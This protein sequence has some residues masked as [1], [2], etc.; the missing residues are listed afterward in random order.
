MFPRSPLVI[1]GVPGRPDEHGFHLG[2][3][4]SRGKTRK[5]LGVH[6]QTRFEE[7]QQQKHR[8]LVT[9][10]L[11]V[12]QRLYRPSLKRDLPWSRGYGGVR[13]DTNS[14][15]LVYGVHAAPQ[16]LWLLC[17]TKSMRI[18]AQQILRS[19]IYNLS[20]RTP[21]AVQTVPN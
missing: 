4:V 12:T 16:Y 19:Y 2:H 17:R 7:V 5:S 11:V 18:K 15:G 10:S 3:H 6:E 8:S 13:S 20:Q 14:C 9:V 1:Q 21:D